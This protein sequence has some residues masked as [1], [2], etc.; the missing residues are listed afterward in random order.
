[1]YHVAFEQ[2]VVFLVKYCEKKNLV[3]CASCFILLVFGECVAEKK[4][5]ILSTCVNPQCLTY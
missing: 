1:M 2:F 5:E 3:T 4:R